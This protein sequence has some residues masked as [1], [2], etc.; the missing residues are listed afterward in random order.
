DARHLL[1]CGMQHRNRAP[2]LWESWL[3]YFSPELLGEGVTALLVM[4]PATG[5]ELLRIAIRASDSYFLSDDAST[6]VT[7]DPPDGE[8][9]FTVRIWDVSPTKAYLWAAGAALG[10]GAAL[11]I[12]PRLAK[13]IRNRRGTNASNVAAA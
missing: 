11:R 10:I 13:R 1:V 5:R 3:E 12:L 6:L 7:V 8:G 9:R 2:Y 4:E